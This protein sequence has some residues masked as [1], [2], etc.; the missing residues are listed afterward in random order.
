MLASCTTV[1]NFPANQPFVYKTNIE[2][3]GKFSKEEQKQLESGLEQQ[4][5]DSIQVRSVSKLIGWRSGP[6]L[7]YT[8]I[9]NPAVYDSANAARSVQFMRALL[10]AQGYFRDSIS[11]DTTQDVHRNQMRTT[12]NFKVL[13]GKLITI[14]SVVFKLEDDTLQKVTADNMRGTLLK[15]G[16]PF[17]K[18]LISQEFDRLVSVYRNNGYLQFSFEDLIAVYDTVGIDLLRPTFDPLEQAQQLQELQRR[19]QNPTASLEIRLRAKEDSSRL[20]RYHIGNITVYPDLS[21][22]TANYTPTQTRSRGMDVISYRGMFKPRL[23]TEHLTMR[24]GDLYSRQEYL[25]TLNRINA[26]GAWR[27]VS[28]DPLPRAETDTVD[29]V[30]KM[31][32]A[33]KYQS[34]LNLEGSQNRGNPFVGAFGFGINAGLNNRNFTRGA[35]QANSNL[36]YGIELGT[37]G[38][39]QTQ[40]IT[41]TNSILF[42]RLIP[43]TRKIPFAWRENARTVLNFNVNNTDRFKWFNLTAFNLN[44]GYSFSRD[45]KLL[46]FTFPNIEYSFITRREELLKRIEQNASYRYIFND[47]LVSSAIIGYTVTGG[48][49]RISNQKRFNIEASGLTLGMVRSPFLDS[50]LYRFVRMDAEFRQTHQMGKSSFAWRVFGGAGI[51]IPRFDGDEANRYLPFFKQ[52][53][54]GGPNSMRAWGLRRLGPGSND[55]STELNVAPE[56]FGDMQ[57]E[58]NVEY[59][60]PMFNVTGIQLNGAVFTDMGNI[61]FLRKNADFENGEFRFDRFYRDLAIG[62][63]AGLRIDFGFFML[64]LDYAYKVK[65]PSRPAN[66]Q[67]LKETKLSDGQ[68]Q[69]G[70]NLPF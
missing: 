67:W 52:Y 45:N 13:P 36:R 24:R 66:D 6:R 7:F 2:V 59:R 47:G 33:A 39:I 41:L 10:N 40:I 49:K 60:F 19:R 70:V 51:G 65:D 57:L 35:N 34:S 42:P 37:K 22:D 48:S 11:F 44:W 29:F 27:L 64:R 12:V 21:A 32:P 17:S 28:M 63:G 1:R 68:F 3:G 55:K 4:L 23:V 56:R 46:S 26:I 25:R 54:G 5:H 30:V 53:F 18:N 62:S 9:V 69:L 50:N 14:D 16:V 20:V 8:E 31:V 61:W 43:R 58:A 15:K 38:E